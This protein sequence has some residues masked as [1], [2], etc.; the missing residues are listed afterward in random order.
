MVLPSHP[1]PITL[2]RVGVLTTAALVVS[3]T[4]LLATAPP[5]WQPSLCALT[6]HFYPRPPPTNSEP[7]LSYFV[8]ISYHPFYSNVPYY[9]VLPTPSY[10]LSGVSTSHP[11]PG[12][13]ARNPTVCHRVFQGI[14]KDHMYTHRY[15]QVFSYHDTSTGP[16][17]PI[18]PL[19]L[20]SCRGLQSN[21]IP[22][23]NSTSIILIVCIHEAHCVHFITYTLSIYT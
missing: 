23:S 2:D 6:S 17:P 14:Y 19:P 1:Y 8:V 15:T 20:L 7:Y 3:R 11:D 13:A 4:T 21:R 9:P 22:I 5:L 18:P 12:N 10:C 16:P